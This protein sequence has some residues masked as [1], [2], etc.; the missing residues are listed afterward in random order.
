MQHLFAPGGEAV[1][2][3][4]ALQQLQQLILVLSPLPTH[5]VLIAAEDTLME[6]IGYGMYTE[7]LD[8]FLPE[9]VLEGV[10]VKELR[11]LK[12]CTWALLCVFLHHVPEGGAAATVLQAHVVVAVAAEARLGLHSLVP[13]AHAARGAATAAFAIHARAAPHP[14]INPLTSHGRATH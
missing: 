2:R 7:I 8:V 3:L 12:G 9:W 6:L 4:H 11:A 13:H 14:T 5:H 1:L 10:L